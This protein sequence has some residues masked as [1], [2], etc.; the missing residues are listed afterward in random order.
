MIDLQ[1]IA[2]VSGGI[3]AV[4]NAQ[5]EPVLKIAAGMVWLCSN[6]VLGTI[7]HRAGLNKITALYCFYSLT[8]ILLILNNI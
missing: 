1:D 2:M 7:A 6:A 4:C 3:G 8:S 5:P